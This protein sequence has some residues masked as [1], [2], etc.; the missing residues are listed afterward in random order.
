MAAIVVAG[1]PPVNR[2]E[3]PYRPGVTQPTAFTRP[4]RLTIFLV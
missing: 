4:L 1:G 3:T 2:A